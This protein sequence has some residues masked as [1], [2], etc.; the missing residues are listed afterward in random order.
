MKMRILL[1]SLS[2]WLAAAGALSAQSKL[3]LRV[4]TSGPAASR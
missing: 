3:H 2:M 1:A 4:F